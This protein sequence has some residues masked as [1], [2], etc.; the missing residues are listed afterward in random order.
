MNNLSVILAF[1]YIL[2]VRL[3]CDTLTDKW[4]KSPKKLYSMKE[5]RVDANF[6]DFVNYVKKVFA[7]SVAL[8][9]DI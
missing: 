4:W 9:V 7:V 1:A 2:C 6:F 5:N 8:K 3:K